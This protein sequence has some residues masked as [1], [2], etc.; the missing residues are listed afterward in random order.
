MVNCSTCIA[1]CELLRQ[2]PDLSTNAFP[3]HL[4][5]CKT[6]ISKL[7]TDISYCYGAYLSNAMVH[8]YQMY[9]LFPKP[10]EHYFLYPQIVT[11]LAHI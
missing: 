6:L 1:K 11:I 9:H 8:I 7:H 10:D 2:I 5:Y 3:G 4:Y